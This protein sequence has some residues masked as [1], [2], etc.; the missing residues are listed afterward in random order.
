MAKSDGVLFDFDG[1]LTHRDTM[2]DF[3]VFLNRRSAARGAAALAML[4]VIWP[5]WFLGHTGRRWL[6]SGLLWL[7]TVGLSR[8]EVIEQTRAFGKTLAGDSQLFFNPAVDRLIAHQSAG[9]EVWIVSGSHPSWI[10]LCLAA[11]GIEVDAIVGS[12]LGWV[13]G[14]L[15]Q[16]VR[17]TGEEKLRCMAAHPLNQPNHWLV[18]YSDSKTDAPLMALADTQVWVRRGHIDPEP[19]L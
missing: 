10:R 14:G 11:R 5:L 9:R 12:R 1:T 6:V 15:V 2:T 17:C 13:S 8:R 4:V 7:G 19:A 3:I 16:G 18:A